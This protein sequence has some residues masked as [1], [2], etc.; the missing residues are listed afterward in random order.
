MII[1]GD[2]LDVLR[3]M[4]EESVNAVVT[5]PPYWR[6][7][8]YH[9]PPTEWP[10]VRWR[11]MAGLPYVH[12]TLAQSVC[13]GL[14]VDPMDYVAHLVL[15]F[16]EV[17]RVLSSDGVIF[18]NIG[19]KYTTSGKKATP[20]STSW[21]VGRNFTQTTI[22]DC[23]AFGLGR[24]QLC[25][26]PQRVILSLQADGWVWRG[27][28]IWHKINAFLDGARDRTTM[29]HEPVYLLSKKPIHYA[30]MI[31]VHQPY[32]EST[33]RELRSGEYGGT[34]SKN[35][36]D[37]G[38][39]DPSAAKAGFIKR[40]T[41]RPGID[42]KGGGQGTGVITI[43]DQGGSNL[44]SVWSI[45]TQSTMGEHTASY[46]EK[47]VEL[48]I[49]M[50]CPAGGVVCDIFS[51]SGTTGLVAARLGREFIGIELNPDYIRMAERRIAGELAQQK[52]ELGI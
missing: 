49:L 43:I 21:R 23:G 2:A 50:G 39:Q 48:C 52:L 13:L 33:M 36:A 38:A 46:P 14:E 17:R 20:G 5:S 28:N 3:G 30:D 47:L 24:K 42:H 26:I 12:T 9:V 8:D 41:V 16:R 22:D 6:K 1:Q 18:L 11:P 25:G 31:Q 32:A 27:E 44:R 29:A 40:H 4:A 15:V 10:E 7:R 34:A 51:G 37:S 19:D 45:P 35:Y